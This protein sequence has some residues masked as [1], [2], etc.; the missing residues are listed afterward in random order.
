MLKNN[1]ASQMMYYKFINQ[2][3]K[4][5]KILNDIDLISIINQDIQDIVPEIFDEDFS[6]E[7]I[8]ILQ[9]RFI[10]LKYTI[11]RFK[12]EKLDLSQYKISEEPIENCFVIFSD[13]KDFKVGIHMFIENKQAIPYYLDNSVK[14]FSNL[15]Q[16]NTI[17]DAFQRSK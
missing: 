16:A 15:F 3:N 6:L 12:K 2:G 5:D 9:R 10:N 7:D 17:I 1:T 11:D 14:G 13:N 8:Q 4:L